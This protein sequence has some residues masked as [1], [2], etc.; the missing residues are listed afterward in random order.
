MEQ[1]LN[2][3]CLIC[4]HVILQHL[5]PI[6]HYL[7]FVFL[8]AFSPPSPPLPLP[9]ITQ[10]NLS[11]VV[12]NPQVEYK[13]RLFGILPSVCHVRPLAKVHVSNLNSDSLQLA[14]GF[15]FFPVKA[16]PTYVASVCL[17]DKTDHRNSHTRVYGA[18][19]HL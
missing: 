3:V 11:E 1:D 12:G 13:E 19:L 14:S 17:G 2:D 8:L 6:C 18:H 15:A 10:L 9:H 7:V 4:N 16:V 5:I